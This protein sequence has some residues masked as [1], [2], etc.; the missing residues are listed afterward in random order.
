MLST[1]EELYNACRA[2]SFGPQCLV[3]EKYPVLPGLRLIS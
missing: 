3:G 1:E 2:F